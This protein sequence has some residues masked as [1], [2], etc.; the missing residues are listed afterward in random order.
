M[1]NF[2]LI[3]TAKCNWSCDY[4]FRKFDNPITTKDDAKEIN[5]RIIK[6][7]PLISTLTDNV[8]FTGGEPG[9][10][11]PSI[12]EFLFDIFKEMRIF[13]FATNGSW[14]KT[15]S[16]T[17]Y[18]DIENFHILYHCVQDLTKE[19]EYHAP[20]VK[21]VK[22][23]FVIIEDNLHQV[24]KFLSRYPNIT[25]FPLYDL[26]KRSL[27][28]K[29][30]Y[31]ELYEIL[32]PFDN[33]PDNFKIAAKTM[34]G[35]DQTWKQE[36]IKKKPLRY[37]I[38]FV[39]NEITTCCVPQVGIELNEENLIRVASGDHSLPID[40][41]VCNFCVVRWVNQSDEIIA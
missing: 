40:D 22:H 41:N 12:L 17:K 3:L 1:V 15:P 36:C 8:L 27:P 14:F 18:K 19:I 2:K 13:R 16:F 28:S 39:K 25:F 23:T 33:I 34:G 31:N 7:S 9:T 35:E 11:K 5:E 30:F 29:K 6:Y 32:K 20:D 26:R 38:D 21:S 37:R 10:V 4:C 24:S